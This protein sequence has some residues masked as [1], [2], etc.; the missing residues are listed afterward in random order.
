MMASCI[1]FVLGVV[2]G[3]FAQYHIIRPIV[4]WKLYK[5]KSRKENKPSEMKKFDLQEW[6]KDQT[7][8]I[9]T[10]ANEPAKVV[11]T[12]G[13]GNYPV[14]VVIWDGDTTDSCWC[15]ADGKNALGMQELYF[16]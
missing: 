7:Q 1:I 13:M 9:V 3:M 4:E 12:E 16:K 15:T 14:L 5:A 2:I 6:L 11:F 8:E 10:M